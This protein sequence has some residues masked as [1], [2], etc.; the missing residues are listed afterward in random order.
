MGLR[1]RRDDDEMPEG[2]GGKEEK[3]AYQA[4]RPSSSHFTQPD[5]SSGSS[6]AL[7]MIRSSVHSL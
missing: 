4:Y 7:V 3:R 5:G 1:D 2:G 6:T